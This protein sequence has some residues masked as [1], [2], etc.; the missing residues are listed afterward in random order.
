M[1]TAIR[2]LSN[3]LHNSGHG[4]FA[5]ILTDLEGGGCHSWAAVNPPG[6]IL[7]LDPQIG[8]ITED[9]P[10]YT[11]H[12]VPTKANIISMDAL[13]VTGEGAPVP[14]PYHGPGQWTIAGGLDGDS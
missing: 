13:V 7:F 12:G 8:R 4:S 14:L 3:H 2:N 6:A 10:L 9:V 1:D 5:F 11:H